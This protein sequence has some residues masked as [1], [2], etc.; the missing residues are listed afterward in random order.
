MARHGVAITCIKQI[1]QALDEVYETMKNLSLRNKIVMIGVLLPLIFTLVLFVMY[2]KRSHHQAVESLV[3][4][5]QTVC[6]S[7]HSIRQTSEKNWDLGILSRS[8]LK[9]W[10]DQGLT[11]RLVS[12]VP[13]AT[14]WQA[15]Q[16]QGQDNGFEFRVPKFQ[17]RNPA[18]KPN[19]MEAEVLTKFKNESLDRY[20]TVDKSNNTLHYFEPIRLT[21]SCMACHGDPSQ[22]ATLWGN[23]QGLDP[24]GAPM[25]NWKVGEIHGAFEVIQSL[26]PANAAIR[27]SLAQAGGV[28]AVGIMIIGLS[29]FFAVGHWVEKP[30]LNATQMLREGAEQVSHGSSGVSAAAQLLADGATNQAA[31]TE[32]I[33]AAVQ[34][35]SSMTEQNA[36]NAQEAKRLADSAKTSAQAGDQSTQRMNEAIHDIQQSSSET[37]KIIKVIDEIAF[38]TNLLALNA[39]VE[40]AR[41][42]EAGKGFAVVAEEVRNLAMRS[43][44]AARNTTSM[45]EE[46]VQNA[47]KGVEITDQVTQSL[48][49]IVTNIAKTTDL[50]NEIADAS[51]EQADAVQ[52]IHQSLNTMESTT[53]SNAASAEESSSAAA[54][55]QHQAQKVNDIIEHLVEMIK[56]HKTGIKMTRQD[57]GLSL[58]DETY[59]KISKSRSQEHANVI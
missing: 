34:E 14:A 24:L 33:S 6:A 27:S 23:N 55:M 1:E 21:E 18:N 47:Q 9:E 40:A 2:T 15:A 3:Q 7:S 56:G 17:P 26:V 39:A 49:D 53:Q 19:A 25:E 52:H 58:S 43:A 22:S 44:E 20:Y 31:T 30:I 42:G 13:I 37:A 38:Q 41:A 4:K 59:H 11:D 57:D 32:E 48:T 12:S 50:V 16:Q 10:A 45:I 35:M 5:A 28:L 36:Q 51:K 46:S 29:F 8:A 54:E